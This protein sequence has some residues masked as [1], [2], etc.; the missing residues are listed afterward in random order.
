MKQVIK[1]KKF[2]AAIAGLAAVIGSSAFGLA[3]E[4]TEKIVMMIGTYIIG[5]GLA[6]FGKEAKK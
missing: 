5:Q 1:S 6:D 4:T 3:P 2:W